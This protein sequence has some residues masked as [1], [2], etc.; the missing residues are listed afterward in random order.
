MILFYNAMIAFNFDSVATDCVMAFL[1]INLTCGHY[2]VIYFFSILLTHTSPIGFQKNFLKFTLVKLYYF[3]YFY[4]QKNT[5][6]LVGDYVIIIF[7]C[8]TL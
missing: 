3:K 1:R 2:C 6:S 5:V 7:Q 8:L 4:E